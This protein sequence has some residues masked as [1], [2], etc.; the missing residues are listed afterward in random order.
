MEWCVAGDT[1]VIDENLNRAKVAFDLRDTSG[2]GLIVGNVPFVGL[3]ACF[4]SEGRS[5][6]IITSIGGSD[7]IA[8]FF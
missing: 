7:F 1:C 8:G 5:L 4:S 6:F 2:T 3:D